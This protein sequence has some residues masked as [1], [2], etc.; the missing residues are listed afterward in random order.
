MTQRLAPLPDGGTI[1]RIRVRGEASGFHRSAGPM[2]GRWMRTSLVR[3]RW[4][5]R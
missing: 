4:S 3:R 5:G 1:A 2:M